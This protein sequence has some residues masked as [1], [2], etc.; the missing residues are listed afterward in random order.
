MTIVITK[1]LTH[2]CKK[3]DLLILNTYRIFTSE[4]FT[5]QIS[6]FFLISEK[7]EKFVSPLAVGNQFQ[8]QVI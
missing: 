1:E 8:L 5:L 3:T 6:Y 4:A 2:P 7:V